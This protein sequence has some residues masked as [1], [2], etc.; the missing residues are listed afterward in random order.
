MKEL[1]MLEQITLRRKIQ[2]MTMRVA[3]PDREREHRIHPVP[4]IIDTITQR[5]DRCAQPNTT[6]YLIVPTRRVIE[7][8]RRTDQRARLRR[9]VIV[10]IFTRPQAK[11]LP[12]ARTRNRPT[13]AR[14]PTNSGTIIEAISYHRPKPSVARSG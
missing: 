14:F 10:R 9:R 12:N 7:S 5:V 2:L 4:P 13:P 11:S 6:H 8:K 1:H 3:V